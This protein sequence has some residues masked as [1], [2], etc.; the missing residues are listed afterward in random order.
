MSRTRDRSKAGKATRPQTA[1]RQAARTRGRIPSRVPDEISE[2]Q[3]D[4]ILRARS[5]F[6]GGGAY[7]IDEV[8]GEIYAGRDFTGLITLLMRYA[9]R[10]DGAPG[11]C[12]NKRCRNGACQLAL[13]ENGTAVC[14][15]GIRPGAIEATALIIGGLVE[16][17]K[18]YLPEWFEEDGQP[19]GEAD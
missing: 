2:E 4:G 3:A 9:Q 6:R 7:G 8:T 17:G 11:R 15:G 14:R 12:R 10:L 18:H 16:V 1:H 19:V 5:C 13:D